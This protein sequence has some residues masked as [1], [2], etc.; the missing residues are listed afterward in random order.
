MKLSDEMKECVL[1]WKET[2]LNEEYYIDGGG[3]LCSGCYD[4][5]YE[6]SDRQIRDY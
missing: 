2:P 6:K 3:Q 5:V 1:C 4:E